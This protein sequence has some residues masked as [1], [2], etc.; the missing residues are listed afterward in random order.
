MRWLQ[1]SVAKKK[2]REKKKKRKEALGKIRSCEKYRLIKCSR[3]YSHTR[4]HTRMGIIAAM[5]H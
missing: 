4:E 5:P 2:K 3:K 1:I